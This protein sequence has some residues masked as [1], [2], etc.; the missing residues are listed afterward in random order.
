MKALL[1]TRE[2]PPH[3]YG[4]AGVVA[5]HLSR[6]LARRILVE[7][8]C[9]GSPAAPPP[10]AVVRGYA[11]WERVQ[12]GADG[13]R[14]AP[15]LEAF[16]VGLAMARDRVDADVVHAHTWYVSLAGLLVRTLHQIPLVLTLHSLEPLRPWKSDQLGTG[17]LVSTG[18]E[19]HAV[20]TADRVIAVSQVMRSDVVKL[21]SIDPARVVV[22]PNGIDAL[23]YGKT[24]DRDAL[25]RYGVRPPYL[26]F[27][28]RIS[29]QKGIFDLLDAA[30][31]LP[32]H[33]QLVL[34]AASPDT[35]EIEARLRRAVEARPAVRWIPEMVPAPDLIQLYSHAAA[36]VCPSVYEP[37]GV[38][39]LEAMACETPVVASAVGG[40]LDVVEDRRTGLLVPPGQPAQLARA[41]RAL[42]DD[43]ARARA[44]GAAGRERVLAHFT[45]ASV[46]EQTE[47]LYCEAVESFHPASIP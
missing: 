32:H 35:P 8:R 42:L 17:Y 4:G 23:H 46:A 13:P 18:V 6:A 34:C 25:V 7:V 47:R 26:L 22:I 15:V 3:V 41:I 24:H 38:I 39:N 14:F 28:G 44:L 12:R 36:F 1:L 19:K 10:G 29:E 21:F 43:P 16:S 5:D 33:V 40:I 31:S 30:Q 9:F 2:Y 45:W 11:P 20:E 27:V 37:F